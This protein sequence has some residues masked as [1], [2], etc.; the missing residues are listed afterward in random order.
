[1][2]LHVIGTRITGF[3]GGYSPFATMNLIN[4]LRLFQPD[5]VHLHDLHGYFLNIATVV[6]FLKSNNIATVWTFHSDFMFTGKCGSALDCDKWK[7][8]CH[9]CPSLKDYPKT[10]YFDQSAKMFDKKYHLFKDFRNLKIITPSEWLASRVRK[11]VIVRSK[12]VSVISNGVDLE[13]FY[14]RKALNTFSGI[15]WDEKFSVLSVGSNFWSEHKGGKWVLSLA[16]R[17]PHVL[18]VIVG[19]DNISASYPNNVKLIAPINDKNLLANFYSAANLTLLTSKQETFSMVTAESLACGTPVVGF[20]S[21]A[22]KE[23]AP[24][25]FGKFVNHGDIVGLARCIQDHIDKSINTK[26]PLECNSFVRSKYSKENMI[27]KYQHSYKSLL[28][29]MEI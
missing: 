19:V 16:E 6:D 12:D 14:P 17:M 24:K 8:H 11:S 26:S 23:V 21:G 5:I 4:K 20:D 27:N 15:N 28:K 29:K 1:M 13:L 2:F 7:S 18:F 3:T 22:P 10:I 25:G 9:S